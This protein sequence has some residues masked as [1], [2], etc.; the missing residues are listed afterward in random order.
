MYMSRTSFSASLDGAE[1]QSGNAGRALRWLSRSSC[2]TKVLPVLAGMALAL[3]CTGA[4]AA[5]AEPT[6]LLPNGG[7]EVTGR[8]AQEWLVEFSKQAGAKDFDPLV[9]VGW[10]PTFNAGVTYEISADAHGGK[11]SLKVTVPKAPVCF[12]SA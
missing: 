3:A 1:L 9:P 5:A 2:V 11:N 8:W 6:N 12:H 4:M 10:I 7:F